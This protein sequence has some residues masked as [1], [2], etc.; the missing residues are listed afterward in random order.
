LATTTSPAKN[1]LTP[2]QP[3]KTRKTPDDDKSL[4]TQ[5]DG[6]KTVIFFC[7]QLLQI[8]SILRKLNGID[9]YK[10]MVHFYQRLG[11]ILILIIF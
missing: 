2:K 7:L 11:V 1:L 8:F 5:T 10:I 3:T 9:F 4:V 6:K